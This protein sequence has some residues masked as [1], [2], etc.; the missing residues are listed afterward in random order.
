[1]SLQP[2]FI[3]QAKDFVVEKIAEKMGVEKKS[4]E[5]K[6]EKIMKLFIP[7]YRP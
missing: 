2:D 3:N 5:K 6:V 1:M 7:K 4:T